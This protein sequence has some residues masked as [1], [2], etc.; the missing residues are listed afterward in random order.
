MHPIFGSRERLALYYAAWLALGM[1]LASQLASVTHASPLWALALALPMALM[2]GSEALS[3]WYL[4]R[5]LPAGQVQQ[6]RLLATWLGTVIMYVAVWVGL[7]LGW[8]AALNALAPAWRAPPARELTLLLIFTGSIGLLISILAHYMAAAFDRTREAERLSLES[9]LQA[10]EAEMS[11]LRAQLDPH[12]LFN[13]L[14]SVAALTHTDPEAARRMC[15]LLADFFR[16]SLTLGAQ[17]SI[18]LSEELQLVRSFLAIEQVRF[19]ERLRQRIEVDEDA[20][21]AP[22]PALLLQPLVEN[23]VH[24]GI[25]QLLNGGEVCLGARRRGGALELT[26]ENPC[27]PE[28]PST[29]GT[30]VGLANVRRRLGN[31]FGARAGLT[32]EALPGRFRVQV[33]LPEG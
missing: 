19:G 25:A 7:A 16:R 8:A 18:A 15:F 20:L 10:R 4:V 9:R 27:D 21:Q 31:R 23:A 28:L 32:V 14:N 26:V 2:L 6:G 5:L 3:C 13:S 12:F 1:L 30:G 29:H 33:L 11:F 22:I 24:H 17:Q